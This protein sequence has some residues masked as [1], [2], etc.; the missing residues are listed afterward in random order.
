MAQH[1]WKIETLES[2]PSVN[3]LE[4]VVA[5]VHWRL[6]GDD[7]TNTVSVYGSVNLEAP[8]SDNFHQYATLTQDQIIEWTKAALGQDRVNAYCQTLDNQLASLSS[9]QRVISEL[10][11][12]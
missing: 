6:F 3:G 12:A 5:V 9:P 2:H 1:T 10:P 11:W 7:G 4:N 8:D